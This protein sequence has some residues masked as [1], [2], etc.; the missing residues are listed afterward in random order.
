MADHARSS[1][2]VAV[3]QLDAPLLAAIKALLQRHQLDIVLL[4]PLGACLTESTPVK[5]HRLF[6]RRQRPYTTAIV[7]TPTWLVWATDASGQ[8]VASMC[9]LTD[10]EVR[11]FSSE[12][13]DDV[14]LE[15]TGFLDP[16]A[17]QRATAFVPVDTSRA[18]NEFAQLVIDTAAAARG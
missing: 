1:R 14:G 18:G 10:A 12:L 4:D 17:A 9:R 16:T 2:T 13:A 6:G 3:D 5:R 7:L 11:R 15:V 8:P